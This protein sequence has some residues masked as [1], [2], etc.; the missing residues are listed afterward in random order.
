MKDSFKN[1]KDNKNTPDKIRIC[2]EQ[3]R[4]DFLLKNTEEITDG[5]VKLLNELKD[6]LCKFNNDIQKSLPF[7]KY[8]WEKLQELNSYDA[9]I[10]FL[11][12]V[13]S[14]WEVNAINAEILH[15][16]KTANGVKDEHIKLYSSWLTYFQRMKELKEE[17][18]CMNVHS[19]N[20]GN[21]LHFP[22]PDRF[23]IKDD[24]KSVVSY[25]HKLLNND[26]FFMTET[27]FYDL[28]ECANFSSIYGAVANNKTKIRYM[29]SYLSEIMGNDW[30]EKAAQS[31]KCS[32]SKCS[33]ANV[34]QY[35]KNRLQKSKIPSI[36]GNKS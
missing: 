19:E 13:I 1:M 2:D 36:K 7:R 4:L 3:E 30:Y 11:K 18:D 6:I 31:I 5:G 17:V 9:K 26:A 35:I 27:Q 33:G 10:I 29:I 22:L 24:C 16:D 21:K 32:K 8:V 28:I 34:S 15:G 25:V 12:E 20:K 14:L 23:T